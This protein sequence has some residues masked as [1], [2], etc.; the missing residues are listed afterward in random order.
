M[1]RADF[2]EYC[3]R[4]LGKGAI[5]INVTDPQVEDRINE[6]LQFYREV[7]TDGIVEVY[8][9]HQ[10][11][12]TD[13]TNGW[14]PIA[15][16][17]T[18]VMELVQI[19]QRSTI[20]GI[21]NIEYQLHLNDIFDLSY[22]GG[23]TNYVQVKQYLGF[24]QDLLHSNDHVAYSR[25]ENRLYVAMDWAKSVKAG[26]YMVARAYRTVDPATTLKVYDD[27]WLKRY[28]TALIQ[29]QWGHNLH[30][31]KE[32]ALLGGVTVNGGEIM[33]M[34]KE[35]IEKLEEDLYNR[36]SPPPLPSVG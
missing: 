23:L 11:T 24:L 17:V 6:A 21:F 30:L 3:L 16:S 34:A 10:I 5:S 12:N 32:V 33:D 19:N 2:K 25:N 1:T 22:A 9:K 13:I 28:A 8:L 36:F 31:F 26:Q 27:R 29:R 4:A 7:H 15:D 14:I 35:E 20:G 18:Q